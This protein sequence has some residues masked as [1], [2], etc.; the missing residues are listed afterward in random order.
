M[1]ARFQER[2]QVR[3]EIELSTRECLVPFLILQPLVENSIKHCTAS[4]SSNSFVTAFDEFALRAFEA[5][6]VDY[7]LKPFDQERFDRAFER[8]E[9][10]LKSKSGDQ[11]QVAQL[12]ERVLPGSPCLPRLVVREAD[13]LFFVHVRLYCKGQVAGICCLS[14]SSRLAS[15]KDR[16]KGTWYGRPRLV[17][18][19]LIDDETG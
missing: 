19:R 18:R 12:L 14:H 3:L 16:Y 17:H 8:C 5:E 6:A 10:R 4:V 9:R 15:L 7:L 11:Q 2:L 13:R 1:K